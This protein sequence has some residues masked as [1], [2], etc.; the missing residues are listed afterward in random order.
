MVEILAHVTNDGRRLWVGSNTA[1]V[2]GLKGSVKRK[3]GDFIR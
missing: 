3:G 1:R 2:S